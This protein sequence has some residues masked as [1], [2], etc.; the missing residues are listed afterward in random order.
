MALNRSTHNTSL[1]VSLVFSVQGT[2]SCILVLFLQET[3]TCEDQ[4]ICN[5]TFK[6]MRHGH[7]YEYEARSCPS[8]PCFLGNC[9]KKVVNMPGYCKT[10]SCS[11]APHPPPIPG[12]FNIIATCT[13]FPLFKRRSVFSSKIKT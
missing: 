2:K 6:F 5:V 1:Q 4:R 8:L 13:L 7:C 11:E 3:F 10:I 9:T 12:N